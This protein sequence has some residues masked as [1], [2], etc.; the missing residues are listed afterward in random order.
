VYLRRVKPAKRVENAL[1]EADLRILGVESF[2]ERPTPEQVAGIADAVAE[3]ERGRSI[4][5][6]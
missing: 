6:G 1:R 3:A 2:R 5:P 4:S